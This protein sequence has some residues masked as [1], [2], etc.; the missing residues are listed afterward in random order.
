[1]F[2]SELNEIVQQQMASGQ[3]SSPDHF[4]LAAAR[5][6]VL[7]QSQADAKFKKEL[8]AGFDQFET[9]ESLALDSPTLRQYFADM[10]GEL[11]ATRNAEPNAPS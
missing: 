4:L 11:A 6:F 3:F 7:H 8:S 2:S 10:A 5:Q 1:M 9:G